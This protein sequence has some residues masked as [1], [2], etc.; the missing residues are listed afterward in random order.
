MILLHVW[1]HEVRQVCFFYRRNARPMNDDRGAGFDLPILI[2]PH[3]SLP[4]LG[5]IIALHGGA[6]ACVWLT[7]LPLW[8]KLA[9]FVL[10]GGSLLLTG[11]RYRYVARLR[12]GLNVRDQWFIIDR[13]GNSRPVTPVSG[14]F[15]HPALAILT[16]ADEESTVY[17]FI[18]SPLNTDPDSR[19]RLR[20]RLRFRKTP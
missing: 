15:L 7:S 9:A 14:L 5:V 10:A 6:A 1:M 4:I 8:I 2:G 18:I 19:R 13:A 20:V 3:P 11:R 12:L 17:P 16:V